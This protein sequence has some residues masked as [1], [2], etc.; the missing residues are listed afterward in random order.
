MQK[1]QEDDS[2]NVENFKH[3]EWNEKLAKIRHA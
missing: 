2:K 1:I 3:Y